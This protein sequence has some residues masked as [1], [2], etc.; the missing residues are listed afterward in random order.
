MKKLDNVQ[1][2]VGYLSSIERDL[3]K[4]FWNNELPTDDVIINLVNAPTYYGHITV[5]KVFVS[6]SGERKSYEIAVSDAYLNR[7]IVDVV[8]T[9]QH[10]NCHLYAMLKGIKDTSNRYVYH[11]KRFAKIASEHALNPVQTH[12]S[13][14]Y[15][16]E[17]TEQLLNYV[18]DRQYTD[19]DM[20]RQSYIPSVGGHHNGTNSTD[21]PTRTPR[22]RYNVHTYICGCGHKI[23]GVSGLNITCNECGSKFIMIN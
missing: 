3:N 22:G 4:T 7:D 23:R 12:S 18:I 20:F 1:R 14:G 19:I 15:A 13:I 16:T 6:D 5:G 11:N 21:V 9:L 8:A 17:A 2:V 10:E